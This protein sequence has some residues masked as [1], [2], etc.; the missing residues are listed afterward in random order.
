[1]I[2]IMYLLAL[3][4]NIIY[5]LSVFFT[6]GLVSST[7]VLDVLALRFLL[8]WCVFEI[9]KKAKIL[10]INICIKDYFGKT[11]RSKYL[12]SLLLAALFEPVLYMLFE[13]LGIAMTTGVMTG[14][15]LSLMP[16]SCVICESILLKDNTSVLEKFFLLVGIAGVVYIAVNSGNSDG[17]NSIVGM[18]FLLLAVVSGALYMVFSRK[19]SDKF[20]SVEITYFASFFGMIIFNALNVTRHLLSGDISEY[21]VPFMSIDNMIGFVF[22]SIVSTIIATGMNNFALSKIKVSTMSA[23]GGISTLVTIATGVL[24]NGEKLYMYHYIGLTLIIVRML[25]VCYLAYNGNKE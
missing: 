13:T 19:S 24:L 1:M 18:I 7:D 16:I 25:G 10:K 23:F 12:K 21:F 8:S 2:F 4:K 3:L 6:G 15:L 22:L 9:L 5:G 11:E 20:T 14:V 17:E